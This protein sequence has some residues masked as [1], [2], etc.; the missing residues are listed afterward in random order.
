MIFLQRAPSLGTF[1]VCH[2]TAA[3]GVVAFFF[4][5]RAMIFQVRTVNF[6]KVKNKKIDI[7]IESI[8]AS[9]NT[10]EGS[11]LDNLFDLFQALWP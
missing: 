5:K 10:S 7:Y 9:I 1:G 2:Y 6:L 4:P 3:S 11:L 8:A